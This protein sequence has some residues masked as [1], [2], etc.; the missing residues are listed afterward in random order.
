MDVPF[1]CKIHQE[2]FYV[3]SG[4]SELMLVVTQIVTNNGPATHRQEF[5]AL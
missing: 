5:S 1:H 3:K 4:F 2:A